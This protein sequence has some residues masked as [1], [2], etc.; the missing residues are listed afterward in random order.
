MKQSSSTGEKKLFLLV[1]ILLIVGGGVLLF[2]LFKAGK[3]P[4]SGEHKIVSARV[5]IE[6]VMETTGV[7]TTTPSV[8]TNT[9]SVTTNTPSSTA[10]QPSST[11]V[12]PVVEEKPS[13]RPLVKPS[14]KPVTK[15]AEKPADKAVAKPVEKTIKQTAQARTTSTAGTPAKKPVRYKPWAVHIASVAS[16]KEAAELKSAVAGKGYKVYVTDFNKEGLKW[17][18]VRVGFY[19]TRKDAQKAASS[20]AKQF[21]NIDAWPVMPSKDEVRRHMN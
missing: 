13:K 9:P 21:E 16:K 4:R 11:A 14:E 12:K 17:Y 5:K 8:T 10:N 1:V 20:L 2:Y 6:T 19:S 3:T 18:R 7:P 15:A